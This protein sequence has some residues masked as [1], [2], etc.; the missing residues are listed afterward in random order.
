MAPPPRPAFHSKLRPAQINGEKIGKYNTR[1]LHDGNEIAFGTSIPQAHNGGLEDY[2]FVYRHTAAGAP[3]TGLYAAY[4]VGIE[5]GKGSFAAVRRAIHK[6][7]GAWYA[8][9]MI[10]AAK[11]VRQNG[12]SRNA[13]FAREISIMEKLEHRNVCKLVEV[14]FHDDNSISACVLGGVVYVLIYGGR[15]GARARG[16][17]RPARAHPQV[18]DWAGGAECKGYHIPDVRRVIGE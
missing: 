13:T 12:A 10:G 3:V 16:G 6:R 17:R 11:T 8:V 14:F 7:S 2:R 18:G 5:L 9:K 15:S 4:D 1:I